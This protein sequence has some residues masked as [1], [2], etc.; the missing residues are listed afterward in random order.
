MHKIIGETRDG[1]PLISRLGGTSQVEGVSNQK[2]G[3]STSFNS[4]PR[5]M[6]T[7]QSLFFHSLNV[8]SRIRTDPKFRLDIVDITPLKDCRSSIALYTASCI[9]T[10]TNPQERTDQQLRSSSG[11]FPLKGIF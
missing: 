8:K 3:R 6:T 7:M 10:G 5:S 4:G 1:L 9:P 2:L 11:F